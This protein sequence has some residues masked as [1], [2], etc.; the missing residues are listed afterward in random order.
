MLF[1]Q[2]Y[3]QKYHHRNKIKINKKLL[4]KIFFFHLM[5][6]SKKIK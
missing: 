2:K 3:V 6:K 5:G 4:S 1:N